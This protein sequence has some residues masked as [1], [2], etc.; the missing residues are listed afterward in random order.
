MLRLVLRFLRFIPSTDLAVLPVSIEVEDI[1]SSVGA[2]TGRAVNSRIINYE[3][4]IRAA[5]ASQIDFL[6]LHVSSRSTPLSM[7]DPDEI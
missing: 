3:N 1:K 5:G 6:Y 2:G 4:S 7:K